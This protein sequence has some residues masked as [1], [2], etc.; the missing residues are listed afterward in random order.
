MS[1]IF[2]A[3]VLCFA[4][5]MRSFFVTDDFFWLYY[6]GGRN[7]W[8]GVQRI[9]YYWLHAQNDGFYRPITNIF[10]CFDFMFW[11]SNPVGYHITNIL[12]HIGNTITLFYWCK[13]ITK[14]TAI[15]LVSA[16]LFSLQPLHTS[17]V[18]YIS[19]RT[20]LIFS[21][22]FLMSIYYTT[23]YFLHKKSKYM[24]ILCYFLAQYSKETAIVILPIVY[25]LPICLGEIKAPEKLKHAR[26]KILPWLIAIAFSYLAIRQFLISAKLNRYGWEI[27]TESFLRFFYNVFLVFFPVNMQSLGIPS[28]ASISRIYLVLLLTFGLAVICVISLFL[29]R[30]IRQDR[31]VFPIITFL[32]IWICFSFFPILFMSG[33]R[34]AYLPSA[35]SAIISAILLCKIPKLQFCGR[36]A[37]PGMAL[38]AILLVFFSARIVNRNKIYNEVGS[39]AKQMLCSIKQQFPNP[40]EGAGIYIVNPPLEWVRDQESWLKVFNDS[41]RHAIRV[42]YEKD[43]LVFIAKNCTSPKDTTKFLKENHIE[44]FINKNKTFRIFEYKNE[45]I[46]DKTDFYV[47]DVTRKARKE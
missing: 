37:A 47:N 11:R 13:L 19:G 17:T 12:L 8:D 26:N 3:T 29:F 45:K 30:F 25:F 43:I 24:A 40:P 10:F 6:Y 5:A 35:G 2:F 27:G 20:E 14:K 21:L 22:F 33:T 28:Y 4:P 34:Y 39:R 15:S 36:Q 46:Y 1:I 41:L 38:A 23:R 16:A 7:F 31:S 18:T 32:T 42:T 44:E 9:I